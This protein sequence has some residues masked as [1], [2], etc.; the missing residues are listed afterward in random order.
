MYQISYNAARLQPN[1]IEKIASTEEKS[2]FLLLQK[3][4]PGAF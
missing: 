2:T 4:P 1:C 3:L